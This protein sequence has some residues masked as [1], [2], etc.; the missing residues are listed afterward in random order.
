LSCGGAG[1]KGEREKENSKRMR[2][3]AVLDG[4]CPIIPPKLWDAAAE[5]ISM[6]E[7]S[8]GCR[9]AVF[10]SVNSRENRLLE[11]S[12]AGCV[13]VRASTLVVSK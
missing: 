10:L 3:A 7:K 4:V 12:N 11:V 1:K 5:P 9:Q 6:S 8:M 2:H 13:F